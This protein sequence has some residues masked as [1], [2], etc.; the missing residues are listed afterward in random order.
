[1]EN[2]KKVNGQK[3]WFAGPPT[4]LFCC[5][6]LLIKFCRAAVRLDAMASISVWYSWTCMSRLLWLVPSWDTSPLRSARLLQS[7]SCWLLLPL[8]SITE[9]EEEETFTLGFHQMH[10]LGLD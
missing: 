5:S 10:Q 9:F 6:V 4:G 7:S 3:R 8:H 1:M 2:M